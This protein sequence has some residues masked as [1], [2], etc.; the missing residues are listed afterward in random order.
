MISK[1]SPW[2]VEQFETYLDSQRFSFHVFFDTWI[3][4]NFP[5]DLAI[6]QFFVFLK[7]QLLSTIWLIWLS[8]RLRIALLCSKK[9][10]T[11]IASKVSFDL[12]LI[13]REIK[14]AFE[15][16]WNYGTAAQH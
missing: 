13:F 5:Q 9:K 7:N 2:N 3:F 11:W 6:F 10:E 8:F 16:P 15:Q 1:N 4:V 12:L 14:E